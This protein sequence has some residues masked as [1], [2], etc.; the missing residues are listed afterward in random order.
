MRGQKP[1]FGTYWGIFSTKR[2]NPPS[3]RGS[4]PKYNTD[5]QPAGDQPSAVPL[6]E[7][8]RPRLPLL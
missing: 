5:K 7:R 8:Y 3:L 1:K 4:R 6:T 2:P